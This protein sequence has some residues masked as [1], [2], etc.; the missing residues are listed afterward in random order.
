MRKNDW[1]AECSQLFPDWLAQH[2]LAHRE[3][4]DGPSLL[5]VIVGRCP[6]WSIPG[7]LLLGDA[8]HPMSPIRAQGI[9]MALRDAIVAANHLVPALRNGSQISPALNAI[10]KER[11]REVIKVQNF[12]SRKSVGS[13]GHASGRG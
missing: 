9:N 7:L 6:Q 11:E 4:L 10:Q 13:A 12:S 1:L 2:V 5:D 3:K 8:A